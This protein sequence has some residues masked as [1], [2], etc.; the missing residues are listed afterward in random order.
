[1]TLPYPLH[2]LWLNNHKP[3]HA[4]WIIAWPPARGYCIHPSQMSANIYERDGDFVNMQYVILS[5]VLS[6][7]HTLYNPGSLLPHM[8]RRIALHPIAEQ[9]LP[10]SDDFEPW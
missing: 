1:M 9:E 10:S 6:A 8:A 5:Q 4:Q 2:V 7:A 3:L